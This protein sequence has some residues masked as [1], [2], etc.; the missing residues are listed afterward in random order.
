MATPVISSVSPAIVVAGQTVTITGTGF[1]GPSVTSVTFNGT[2]ATS[3]VVVSAT[4][5]TAVVPAF[6]TGNVVVDN[7]A[8]SNGVTA[9]LGTQPTLTFV[10][11]YRLIHHIEGS[12]LGWERAILTT[13]ANSANQTYTARVLSR[14]T[15]VI[16]IPGVQTYV[17]DALGLTTPGQNGI[18][19]NP[20]NINQFFVDGSKLTANTNIEI[21]ILGEGGG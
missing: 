20:L 5:I 11:K 16:G 18:S 12:G 10:E 1:T 6:T 2:N 13:G 7:G 17:T 14:V 4:V 8:A 15:G 9:T 21:M 3:F 19:A